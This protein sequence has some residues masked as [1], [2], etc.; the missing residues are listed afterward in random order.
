VKTAASLRLRRPPPALARLKG[1]E[2]DCRGSARHFEPNDA[3]I[4]AERQTPVIRDRLA[5]AFGGA[6]SSETRSPPGLQPPACFT[7]PR[8]ISGAFGR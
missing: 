1:G 8:A 2:N 3:P 7:R 6:R 5:I 4:A